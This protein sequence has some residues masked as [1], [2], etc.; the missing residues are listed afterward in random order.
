M[1]GSLKLSIVPISQNVMQ[2]GSGYAVTSTLTTTSL[3]LSAFNVT[4]TTALS[5]GISFTGADYSTSNYVFAGTSF[6]FFFS[7]PSGVNTADIT[8]IPDNPTIQKC[9]RRN[10]HPGRDFL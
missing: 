7:N 4:V 9:F 8:D 3:D 5:S 2:G 1:A 6:D 10:V